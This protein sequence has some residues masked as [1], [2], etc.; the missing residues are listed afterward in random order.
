MHFLCLHFCVFLCLHIFHMV[1][2]RITIEYG[3]SPFQG[4]FLD[5]CVYHRTVCVCVRESV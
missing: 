4:V 3:E 5:V 1:Q 2:K